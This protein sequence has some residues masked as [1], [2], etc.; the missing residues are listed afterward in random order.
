MPAVLVGPLLY[1]VTVRVRIKMLAPTNELNAK[2]MSRE[3][4]VETLVSRHSDR[5]NRS[6]LRLRARRV[7]KRLS[8]PA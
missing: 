6:Q 8:G 7:C 4:E 2:K 3:S 1:G 5:Y